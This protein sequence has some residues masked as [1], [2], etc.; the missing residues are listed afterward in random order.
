MLTRKTTSVHSVSGC[1]LHPFQAQGTCA[2]SHMGKTLFLWILRS[3]VYSVRPPAKSFTYPH[4][5]KTF[6]LW[7][8]W[9]KVQ[10]GQQPTTACAHPHRRKTFLLWVLWSKVH[11]GY[12]PKTACAHPHRGKA[13]LLWVLWSKVHSGQHLT[14]ACAHPHRGK[15]F[16][17]WV[18][19]SKVHQLQQP[20]KHVRRERPF[21]C[22]YCEANFS[23]ASNL[24]H[25]VRTPTL[26][27]HMRI[28]A[29][30][31]PF[32]CGAKG[33][34]ASTLQQH[35]EIHA[36]WIRLLWVLRNKV[37]LLHWP[38]MESVPPHGKH[39]SIAKR[40]SRRNITSKCMSIHTSERL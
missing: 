7:L 24:K 22:E 39:V 30:K 5:G 14:K 20:T 36:R 19:W 40:I 3:E 8:L 12:H 33:T 29:G 17:L 11:S 37:L 26:S 4:R 10:S 1:I 32:S 9:S 23:D 13:F 16:L 25:H 2:N 31:K 38:N 15:A 18:L 6:F 28:H 35:V 34:Q 27:R 21:S